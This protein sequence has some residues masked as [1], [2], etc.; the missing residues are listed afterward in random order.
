MLSVYSYSQSIYTNRSREYFLDNAALSSHIYTMWC[1]MR[2]VIRLQ[3]QN[4]VVWL[5]L[6]EWN[7]VC[8]TTWQLERVWKLTS[9]S[10]WCFLRIILKSRS[11]FRRKVKR[12]SRKRSNCRFH[13]N[14]PGWHGSSRGN[15]MSQIL[16]RPFNALHGIRASNTPN[17]KK[18]S[19]AKTPQRQR[20]VESGP[21]SVP[22]LTPAHRPHRTRHSPHI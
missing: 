14:S 12:N 7:T 3:H 13:R 5:S 17:V 19:D 9:C 8:Y 1:E 6:Q 11:L 20:S 2:G 21:A 15:S 4:S 16:I 18:A 10:V 22:T